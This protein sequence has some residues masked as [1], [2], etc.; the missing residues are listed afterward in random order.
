MIETRFRKFGVGTTKEYIVIDKIQRTSTE[1]MFL[2]SVSWSKLETLVAIIE[3][4]TVKM[5]SRPALELY[6]V[7]L[8]NLSNEA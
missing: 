1:D 8:I 6:I 3:I 5:Y 7:P 4:R 2:K